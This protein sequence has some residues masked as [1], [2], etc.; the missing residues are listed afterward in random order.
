M[1]ASR[2]D[3]DVFGNCLAVNETMLSDTWSGDDPIQRCG[4]RPLSKL[5]AQK[6]DVANCH[7]QE[8]CGELPPSRTTILAKNHPKERSLTN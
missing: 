6:N 8:R 5:I 2:R 7:P 3:L 4:E 1:K